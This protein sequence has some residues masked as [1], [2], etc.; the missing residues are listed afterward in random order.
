MNEKFNLEKEIEKCDKVL[1]NLFSGLILSGFGLIY[2]SIIHYEMKYHIAEYNGDQ[3][4][5]KQATKEY[6]DLF[7]VH[8]DVNKYEPL[9]Q[10]YLRELNAKKG[11]QDSR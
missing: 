3:V 8:G 4:G 2:G 6:D 10:I 9:R 5:M 1:F 7:K 11:H